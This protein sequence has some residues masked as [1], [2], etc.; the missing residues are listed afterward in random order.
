ML[1]IPMLTIDWATTPIVSLLI[2]GTV[3]GG[4]RFI[5]KAH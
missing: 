3:A 5:R 1:I 2:K 4:P